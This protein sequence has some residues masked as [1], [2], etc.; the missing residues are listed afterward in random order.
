MMEWPTV[1]TL[2]NHVCAPEITCESVARHHRNGSHHGYH[3]PRSPAQVQ[4]SAGQVPAGEDHYL[5]RGSAAKDRDH[6]LQGW[7]QDLALQ[8]GS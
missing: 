2:P 5:H 7:R 8:P 3:L 6:W 1:S 4:D